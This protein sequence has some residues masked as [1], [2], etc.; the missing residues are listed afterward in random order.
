NLLGRVQGYQS[1]DPTLGS[2]NKPY[3]RLPQI[4]FHAYLPGGFRGLQLQFQAEAVNFDR[5][6]GRT[7]GRIDLKPSLSFPLHTRAAFLIPKLSLRHTQYLL[8]NTSP[9]ATS[10]KEISRTVPIFSLDSGLL[11][12]RDLESGRA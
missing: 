5:D 3:D 4:V 8:D 12:E 6:A 7:G 10:S 11:L 1:M 9:E 2:I